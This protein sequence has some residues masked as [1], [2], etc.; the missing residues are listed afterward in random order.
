V[1]VRDPI[2]GSIEISQGELQVLDTPQLQR[3][4]N[5]KQ[6]GF[7]DLAFPGATHTRYLHSIGT[8]YLAGR[9]FDSIFRHHRFT[10]RGVWKTYRQI[11]RLAA[12]L[13]D[14]GHAPLS[15]SAESAMPPVRR[16]DL[17]CLASTNLSRRATHEDYGLKLIIDSHLGLVIR[18]SFEDIL[19]HHVAALLNLDIPLEDDI[20]V[21]DGIDYRTVLSQIVSS[22]LDTDR[23]D[24]LQRDSYFAGVSYGAYDVNWILSNLTFHVADTGKA[25]LALDPRALYTFN[26]FLIAR[27]HMFLMVYFHHKPVM[28]EEMLKQY[29][30]SP[31]GTYAIPADIEQYVD[32]DDY[33]L[34]HH[35]REEA[36][37]GH[38]WARR[39]VSRNPY[40]LLNE[41]H[42]TPEEIDIH[43]Y[44]A[45]LEAEGI[46]QIAT[47]S[48]GSVSKYTR[49]T[50]KLREGPPIF[51]VEKRGAR[52]HTLAQARLLEESTDLF[53]KYEERRQISRIYVPEEHESRA[54]EVITRVVGRR[55]TSAPGRPASTP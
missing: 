4:R 47:S 12:L 8:M 23:M 42:G 49:P 31:G 17:Q 5:I 54:M 21:D 39:I 14:V 9:A 20:F 51:T 52:R 29:F 15:H 28:F 25:H 30:E 36:R 37:R 48:T 18:H 1:E 43:P 35:L 26:D 38:Q 3:L 22:E 44:V 50:E 40:R 19:P 11:V 34:Y 7:A 16:L 33:H 10:R 24:Y 41:W 55:V 46:P 45:A 2:H 13:H 27:F 32:I 6:L 53:A